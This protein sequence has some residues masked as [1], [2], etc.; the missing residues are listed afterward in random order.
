MTWAMTS[1]ASPR[2]I[3]R[4][5][6]FR[7][8]LWPILLA[9]LLMEAILTAGREAAK[10]IYLHG[11][12]G[13]EG[14]VS[15]FLLLAIALQAMLG[16]FGIAVM[17]RLLPQADAHLRWPPGRTYV[18]LACLIGIA[19]GLVMLLADYWPALLSQTPPNTTYSQTPFDTAGFLIGMLTTGLA[20]ETI[21][22]G[23]LVGFL[24]VLVPGRLR[25]G[26]VDLPVAGY[27]VAL[28]FGLAHWQTFQVDPLHLALAQQTYAF[29]WGLTYVWLMERSKSL[30]APIMAHGIG[31]FTEV[32]LIVLLGYLWS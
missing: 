22:R 9:A 27:I 12:A 2:P 13:W 21:F 30:L 16:L 17:Q 5:Y 19:M 26:A 4:L 20:E 29:L 18:G 7:F 15:I 24:L 11:P 3:L 6:G 23:L 10:W 28:L 1:I 25:I 8:R 32:G 31:N 14:H